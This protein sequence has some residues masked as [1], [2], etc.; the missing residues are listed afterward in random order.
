VLW[1]A[2]QVRAQE[3]EALRAAV[4]TVVARFRDNLVDPDPTA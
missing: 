2:S 1:A 4:D 3:L